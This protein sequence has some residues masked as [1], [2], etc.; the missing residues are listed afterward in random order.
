MKKPRFDV[1]RLHEATPVRRQLSS[2]LTSD[3]QFNK[4]LQIVKRQ[5]HTIFYLISVTTE[6]IWFLNQS[7]NFK[8]LYVNRQMFTLYNKK[9]NI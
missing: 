6:T 4:I 5:R 7:E 3:Q 2:G 1:R 8:K 9:S